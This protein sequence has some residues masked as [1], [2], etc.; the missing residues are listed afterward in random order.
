MWK[1]DI[2]DI[3]VAIFA[4]DYLVVHFWIIFLEEM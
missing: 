4:H 3:N 2:R 1:K